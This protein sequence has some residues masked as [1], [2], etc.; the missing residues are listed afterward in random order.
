MTTEQ[1]E[2]VRGLIREYDATGVCCLPDHHHGLRVS[3]WR[4]DS[5]EPCVRA[6]VGVAGTVMV[7][8]QEPSL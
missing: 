5:S 7:E 1:I 8:A 3:I 2:A 4:D 6:Y